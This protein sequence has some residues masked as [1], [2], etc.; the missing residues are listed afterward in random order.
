ML[1]HTE[2]HRRSDQAGSISAVKAINRTNST[3]HAI[4]DGLQV[5]S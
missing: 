1:I 4:L 3:L 2:Q 5:L